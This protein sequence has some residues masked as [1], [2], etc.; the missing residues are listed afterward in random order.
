M[1]TV[2]V[3]VP[4]TIVAT[5]TLNVR[6]VVCP[7]V[8]LPVVGATVNHGWDGAPAVHVNV[9]PPV[10]CRLMVCA[11]GLLPTVVVN[12]NALALSTIWGGGMVIVIA[13]VDGLPV[14]GRPVL[15]SVALTTTLVETVVPPGTPVALTMTL[16]VVVAPPARPVPEGAES[17]T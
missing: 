7:A 12:V 17:E 15:G 8:S 13:T 3:Y 6:G 1:T 11:A 10:F 14:T 4:A 5:F 16:T 9:F 2:A